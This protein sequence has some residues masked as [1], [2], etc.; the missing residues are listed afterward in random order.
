MDNSSKIVSL[1][2]LSMTNTAQ[3]EDGVDHGWYCVQA[4]NAC[5]IYGEYF[6]WFEAENW[7]RP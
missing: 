7:G 4:S 3:A 1:E 6:P 2:S 5:D